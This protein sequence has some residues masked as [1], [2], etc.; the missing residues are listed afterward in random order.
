[1]LRPEFTRI[2]NPFPPA[3]STPAS[4]NSWRSIG[5]PVQTEVDISQASF[6]EVNPYSLALVSDRLRSKIIFL[7]DPAQITGRGEARGEISQSIPSVGG[8]HCAVFARVFGG[9]GSLHCRMG[10]GPG[11]RSDFGSG[12]RSTLRVGD[13]SADALSPQAFVEGP[14]HG[15]H[16][17]RQQNHD[18]Q[19]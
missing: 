19:A 3:S 12:Q 15:T 17:T 5:P 13:P 14:C 9:D 6:L 7:L 8:S 1:M 4:P 18:S 11:K 16:G 2:G 10:E